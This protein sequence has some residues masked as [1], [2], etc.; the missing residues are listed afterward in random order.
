MLRFFVAFFFCF[1]AFVYLCILHFATQKNQRADITC[2]ECNNTD[3]LIYLLLICF[4]CCIV[5]VG[6]IR[7]PFGALFYVPV[8]FFSFFL[9]RSVPFQSFRNSFSRS[10]FYY[11]WYND[12]WLDSC[13]S[14]KHIAQKYRCTL[15]AFISSVMEVPLWDLVFGETSR[16]QTSTEQFLALS[17]L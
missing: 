6:V 13:V 8:F 14:H 11:N 1:F 15:C 3:S 12:G 16:R 7:L 4:G 2:S 17:Y 5:H 9:L 10:T